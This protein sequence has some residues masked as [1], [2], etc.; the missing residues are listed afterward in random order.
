MRQAADL[1]PNSP[2]AKKA[3][4]IIE[5]MRANPDSRIVPDMSFINQE[6]RE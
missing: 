2:V 1:A 4:Y 6:Y 3:K 5:F